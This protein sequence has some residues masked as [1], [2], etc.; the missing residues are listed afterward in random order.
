MSTYQP[1]HQYQVGRDTRAAALA[2][3]STAL[4]TLSA[5]GEQSCEL[6]FI[7]R[8][9]I[10]D[11]GLEFRYSLVIDDTPMATG[12]AK[13]RDAA[14]ASAIIYGF[15]EVSIWADGR[16]VLR[17]I[18]SG[19]DDFEIQA[20]ERGD[21]EQRMFRSHWTIA[22]VELLDLPVT[23]AANDNVKSGVVHV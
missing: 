1:P 3:V 9:H 15:N 8:R 19:S 13:P 7:D 4:E 2:L 10:S 6:L 11:N 14:W 20:F 16:L 17:V 22:P 18:W 5:Y 21:W 12:G 23:K